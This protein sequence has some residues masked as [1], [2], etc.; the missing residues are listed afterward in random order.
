MADA[1]EPDSI[2]E[3]LARLDA[4]LS[5]LDAVVTR[6]IETAAQPDD[7]DAELALM[8]EDRTRLAAA[9]DAA[10]ARLAEVSATTGE[11][12]QRLDRAIETVQD[13]LGRA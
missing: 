2:D 6:R 11:V 3:A 7:R 10:S 5:R 9:L 1:T 12:G 13:V 4:A 8:D